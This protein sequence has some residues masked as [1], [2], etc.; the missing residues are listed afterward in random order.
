MK[1]NND[2]RWLIYLIV[3]IVLLLVGFVAYIELFA[4]GLH[5]W[6]LR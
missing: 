6:L 4:G 3:G 2:Y 1:R 5:G